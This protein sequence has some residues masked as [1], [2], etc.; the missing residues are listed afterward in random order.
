MVSLG[1][2]SSDSGL[3]ELAALLTISEGACKAH[4]GGGDGG[5]DWLLVCGLGPDILMWLIWDGLVLSGPAGVWPVIGLSH[6]DQGQASPHQMAS[7]VC[8]LYY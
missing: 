5:R 2:P 8:L 4:G 7:L 6:G 3:P 1:G